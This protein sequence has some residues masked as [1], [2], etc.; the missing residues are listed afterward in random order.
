MVINK[1]INKQATKLIKYV[2]NLT[3]N[4]NDLCL[5]K[6]NKFQK[7]EYFDFINLINSVNKNLVNPID[8]LILA[9]YYIE[10]LSNIIGNSHNK[11]S[12]MW[13]FTLISIKYLI[14]FEDPDVPFLYLLD[15]S[16]LSVEDYEIIE[17][18]ILKGL[19]WKLEIPRNRYNELTVLCG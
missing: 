9:T 19:N 12:L 4:C 5:F 16:G 6:S 1:L 8:I 13:I 7:M 11:I 3:Y 10:K 2:S 15:S 17:L 18:N 14:E